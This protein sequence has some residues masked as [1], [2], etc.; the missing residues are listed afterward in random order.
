[1]TRPAA[2]DIQFCGTVAYTYISYIFVTDPNL[3]AINVREHPKRGDGVAKGAVSEQAAAV[4]AGGAV[5]AGASAERAGDRGH[6]PRV[7]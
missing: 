4:G 1:M 6:I 5:P 2:T 7:G 3:P